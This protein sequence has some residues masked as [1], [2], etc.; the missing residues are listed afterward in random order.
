VGAGHPA[1]D[2]AV[3]SGLSKDFDDKPR[4]S[5][6]SSDK[7]AFEFFAKKVTQRARSKQESRK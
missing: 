2:A 5:G 4:V 6:D 3:D 1:I 7:G